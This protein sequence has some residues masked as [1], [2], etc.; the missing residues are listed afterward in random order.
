[1]SFIESITAIQILIGAAIML[2]SIAAGLKIK[3]NV[4]KKLRA[5][6]TVT[7]SLMFFFFFGY[8]F[9]A[10]VLI[11]DIA[12]A[13]EIITGTIFLG[14]ACFVY[15]VI[16][17]SQLTIRDINEKD[18][19]I[20][21]YAKSLAN[22]TSDLEKEIMERK[23]ADEALKK[24]EE[25]YRSLVESTDDSICVVNR[26]YRYLFIN[27][28]H[29]ARL[30]LSDEGYI[31]RLYNEFHSPEETKAFIEKA[32]VV[33]NRGESVHHEYQSLRDGRYFLL[34]LSPAQRVEGTIT[35]ITVISKEI[36]DYKRMQEQLRE[37]SLTDQ[38]TCIYN[39][40]GLF[41]LVDPMLKQAKRQKKGIFM[42]YADIDN[43][44]EINDT[45]GHRE[46]DAALIE[47]VNIL[48]T[49]YRESDIIA[50]IGGDE[51]VV[52]PVGTT[53][54]NIE[55]IVDRLEKSLEIYNSKRTHDYR[56]SLSIGVTYY[57]PENPCTIEELLTQAD[58]LMY[59]Y[60][61]NKKQS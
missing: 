46:G 25:Q 10:M 28:K 60:K 29:L 2:F 26:N 9:T 16:R 42:L 37:L 39:R 31:G 3:K 54:D 38:L 8:V 22:R 24:S 57:D 21:G 43:M 45:F 59:K 52:I 61:K 17:L 11:L 7:L 58:E 34:T 32:E 35:A 1:M 33:F 20:N 40:R 36:T 53:G 27:K 55:K 5:K 14:G 23:K 12:F 6:W 41:T 4:S 47:T 50:R 18:K 44:K 19:H 15:V 49:N 51:F 30:G 13:L 48:R 56:L